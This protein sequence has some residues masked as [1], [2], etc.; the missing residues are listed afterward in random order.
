MHSVLIREI[1]VAMCKKNLSPPVPVLRGT[2]EL[3][4][5]FRDILAMIWPHQNHRTPADPPMTKFLGDCSP[6]LS[7]SY[8][9]TREEGEKDMDN[10]TFHMDVCKR[11]G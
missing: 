2:V 9:E 4:P 8:F 10:L 5:A 6:T 7:A 1:G 3:Q 11:E